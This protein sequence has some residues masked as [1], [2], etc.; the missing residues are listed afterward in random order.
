[1]QILKPSSENEM[2]YEF[3]KMEL[4]SDRYGEKIKDALKDLKIDINVITNADL[5]SQQE[6]IKRAEILK[7]YRGYPNEELFESFP[8][9]IKWFW[10]EFDNDDISKIIYITYSYWDELS[11]YTGSPVEAGKII[12]SGKTIF[13]V[14]NDNFIKGADCI[15]KGHKFPP[16]IFLTDE[17]E[18]RYIILEGHGR[19]TAYGLVPD[20]FQNVSVLLGYCKN[21]ELNKWYGEILNCQL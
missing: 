3:L 10:T 9:D 7:R 18:K 8:A 11:N 4:K 16:L 6:N 21:E 1:M 14:P 17:D 15:R 13:D 5:T 20:L 12:R 2:I 19:M